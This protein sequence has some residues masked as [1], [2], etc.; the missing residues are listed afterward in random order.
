MVEIKNSNEAGER[1]LQA[2]VFFMRK[3]TMLKARM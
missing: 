3:I 1:D 2:S